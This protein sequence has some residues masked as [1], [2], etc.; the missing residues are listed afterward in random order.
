MKKQPR[1]LSI[2][3]ETLYTLDSGSLTNAAGGT[4][5]GLIV[6]VTVE[7][8]ALTYAVYKLTTSK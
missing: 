8:L 6:L 5:P 2:S 4:T 3:R 1:R 7:C